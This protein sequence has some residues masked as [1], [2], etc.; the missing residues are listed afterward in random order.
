MADPKQRLDTNVQG[1]FFV[2][3]TCINCDTCRQLAPDSFQEVG[4][5]SAVVIQPVGDEG[6]HRAYQALLACPVGSIGTQRSDK[7]RLQQAMSS[8]P[9]LIEGGVF[10]CGFNSQKSFGANSYF[11]RHS[12]GNWLV[13]SPRYVKHLVD[14]LERMGGLRYIFLTHEDDVADAA[15]YAAR[16]GATRIIHRADAEAMPDAEW[17]VDGSDSIPLAPQFNLIP[18]PGHTPGSSALLYD[19]R[20]LFTGD[21]LWWDPETRSL[22]AP[23]RLVWRSRAMVQSLEKLLGDQFEWVLPGHGDRIKL[24]PEEMRNQ[25]RLLVDHRL[26]ALAS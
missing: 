22:Q 18:V 14:A 4:E 2:D 13:D 8:F 24:T 19:Q 26:A 15:R 9:L 3:A 21:H 10:Y 25:L 20:F 5:C 17:I 1:N 7:T 12:D 23:Q 6:L 16:F 11:I